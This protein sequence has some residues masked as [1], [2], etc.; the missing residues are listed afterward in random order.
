MSFYKACILSSAHLLH[1]SICQL[2]HK[3]TL[4]QKLSKHLYVEILIL[5]NIYIYIYFLNVILLKTTCIIYIIWPIIIYKLHKTLWQ[6]SSMTHC[7][8]TIFIFLNNLHRA[9]FFS[10]ECTKWKI[11]V[12]ILWISFQK[13]SKLS[14]AQ[15]LLNYAD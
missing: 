3:Q 12:I 9:L 15:L 5:K 2:N 14:S 8:Y 7:F 13:A 1:Y 6:L 11:A 4:L 10:T